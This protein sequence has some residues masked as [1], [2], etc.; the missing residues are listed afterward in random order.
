[1][2]PPEEMIASL[3][4]RHVGDERASQRD[5]IWGIYNCALVVQQT[6]TRDEKGAGLSGQRPAQATL[7]EPPVQ[8]RIGTGESVSRIENRIPCKQCEGALIAMFASVLCGD[9]GSCIARMLKFRGIGVAVDFQRSDSRAGHVEVS[10]VHAVDDHRGSLVALCCRRNEC[11]NER[12]KV[13]DFERQPAEK[14]L[15]DSHRVAIALRG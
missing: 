6:L 5:R 10:P 13:I 14:S 4:G 1:M 15:V 12:L 11:V 9:F 8:V 2:C 3:R 7:Y